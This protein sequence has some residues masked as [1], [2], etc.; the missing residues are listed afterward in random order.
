M[1]KFYSEAKEQEFWESKGV[2]VTEYF[3]TSKMAVAKFKKL[4]PTYWM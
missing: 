4:R 2:D 3:D 1:P